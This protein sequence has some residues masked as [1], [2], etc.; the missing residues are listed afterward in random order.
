MVNKRTTI[1]NANGL[2]VRPFNP[3]PQQ[4]LQAA[5]KKTSLGVL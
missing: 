1:V 3:E 4:R 2:Y 5:A